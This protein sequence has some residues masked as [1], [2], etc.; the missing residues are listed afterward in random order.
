MQRL[1][2]GSREFWEQKQLED[3]SGGAGDWL[4]EG[5]YQGQGRA[6]V[7][8]SRSWTV[9]GRG[10]DAN[11]AMSPGDSLPSD[12]H[13]PHLLSGSMMHLMT[14]RTHMHCMPGAQ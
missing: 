1:E 11:L 4:R 6:A 5:R 13:F 9:G 8:Q 12:P 3:V 2:A 10:Q 14:Q 7:W